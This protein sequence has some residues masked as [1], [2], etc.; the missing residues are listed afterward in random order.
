MALQLTNN[1]NSNDKE[2]RGGGRE[3]VRSSHNFNW[4]ITMALF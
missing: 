2:M 4:F 3:I 1:N